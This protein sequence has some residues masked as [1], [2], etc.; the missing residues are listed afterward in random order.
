MNEFREE[1]FNENLAYP[2]LNSIQGYDLVNWLKSNISATMAMDFR[3]GLDVNS[4]QSGN[5][6]WGYNFKNSN[7]NQYVPVFRLE[8]GE[9]K[10][11]E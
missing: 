3:R 11:I 6:T 4:F 10:P 9:L 2:S 8:S 1:F 7:N 5:L